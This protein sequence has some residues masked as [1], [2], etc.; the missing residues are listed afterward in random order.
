MSVDCR[1]NVS[2]CEGSIYRVLDQSGEPC[3]GGSSPDCSSDLTGSNS[4]KLVVD[5]NL[6]NVRGVFAALN[7]QPHPRRGRPRDPV[8][9]D[10]GRYA[11]FD[12]SYPR[13]AFP[14]LKLVT[15]DPALGVVLHSP[16]GLNQS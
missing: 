16:D 2:A 12:Q 10:G 8:N 5:S 14:A 11:A 6:G 3:L 7:Q 9:G 13:S 4:L 15:L 1:Q